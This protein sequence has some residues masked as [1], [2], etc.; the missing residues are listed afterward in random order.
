MNRESFGLNQ[1]DHIE[2]DEEFAESLS[3]PEELSKSHTFNTLSQVKDN[4][5][6]QKS[7]LQS[8]S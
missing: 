6:E 7:S 5:E 1:S 8:N 4:S 2:S 3:I